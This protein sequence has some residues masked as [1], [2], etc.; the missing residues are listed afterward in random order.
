MNRG[1]VLQWG[2]SIDTDGKVWNVTYGGSQKPDLVFESFEDLI[3][4]LED[5]N[6]GLKISRL[7]KRNG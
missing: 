4:W 1:E 6:E 5:Q 7:G 2:L 3:D